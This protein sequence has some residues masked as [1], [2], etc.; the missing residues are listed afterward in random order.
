MVALFTG[1]AV[2]GAGF[3]GPIGDWLGRRLTIL[4]GALIFLVGGCIQT[5]AQTLNYLYAGRALAGL[6][7]GFLTM[8]IRYVFRGKSA[9]A[10]DSVSATLMYFVLS[11]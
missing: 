3:A 8:I 11:I 1:G 6:G 2:F 7:V 10:T 9:T 4:L 5:A